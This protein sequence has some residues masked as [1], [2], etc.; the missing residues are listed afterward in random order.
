M[1]IISALKSEATAMQNELDGQAVKLS[2]ITEE[3]DRGF[4]V[5]WQQA[6]ERATSSIIKIIVEHSCAECG[7]L[8]DNEADSLNGICTDCE[9]ERRND[10]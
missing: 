10:E 1:T 8:I 3:Y 7:C 9:W 2:G 5:G 6:L 4:I